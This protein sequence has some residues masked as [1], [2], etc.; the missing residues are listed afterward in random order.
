MLTLKM[1]EENIISKWENKSVDLKPSDALVV[2]GQSD[3]SSPSDN[4]D[5]AGGNKSVNSHE[6]R[7]TDNTLS[8]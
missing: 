6:C 8:D 1:S 5:K 2:C 7:S 4:V 3:L